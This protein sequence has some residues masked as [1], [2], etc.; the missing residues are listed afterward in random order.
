MDINVTVVMQSA[1][2]VAVTLTSLGTGGGGTEGAFL[3]A[4]PYDATSYL[5]WLP[6]GGFKLFIRGVAVLEYP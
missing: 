6:T 3:E 1:P 4:N 5:E 2:T